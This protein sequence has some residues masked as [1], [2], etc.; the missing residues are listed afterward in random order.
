MEVF[1]WMWPLPLEGLALP[2]S[3]VFGTTGRKVRLSV[4][5][6]WIA[7]GPQSSTG[8]DVGHGEGIAPQQIDVIVNQ[9]RQSRC[10]V[11]SDRKSGV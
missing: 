1:G 5:I 2:E 10:I 9:G 7:Q 6:G 8:N 4:L 11:I 3:G